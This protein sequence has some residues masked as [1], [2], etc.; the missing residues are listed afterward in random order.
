MVSATGGESI[1]ASLSEAR[2]SNRFVLCLVP[3]TAIDCQAS[4]SFA[5]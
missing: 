1:L 5:S 2:C 4:V 3:A